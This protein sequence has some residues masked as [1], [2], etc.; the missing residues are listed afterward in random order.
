MPAA[1]VGFS[2]VADGFFSGNPAVD[3]P[4]EAAGREASVRRGEG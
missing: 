1:T 2:L 4:P 3:L